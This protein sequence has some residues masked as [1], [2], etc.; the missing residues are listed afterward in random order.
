MN[1]KKII[2][3][4]CLM[5]LTTS[6][7]MFTSCKKNK[8]TDAEISAVQDGTAADGTSQETQNLA[9]QA[10]MLGTGSNGMRM[11]SNFSMLSGCATITD[12]TINNGG[13][14]DTLTVDF[15]ASPCQCHDGRFRSGKI[16][17]TY[18]GHYHDPGAVIDLHFVNYQVGPSSSDMFAINNSSTK[19]IVNNG[20]Y[21]STTFCSWTITSNMS[22]VKPNG[23]GT[24]TF[25]ES[26]Q[27]VQFAGDPNHHNVG[28][29]FYVSGTAN[30]TAAN[31]TS[32]TAAT[33]SGKDLVRDMS[34]KK[35]F[36]QG[37]LD[38][39]PSGKSMIAIDFGSGT[40]DNTA[41]ITRNG[42]TRTITLR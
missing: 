21:N 39:T 8:L 11:T 28:N 3:A 32:Y 18:T 26:K 36:T 12:D 2:V 41:T 27:R 38:I 40:C 30:G 29:K 6:T 7:L 35:H 42:V 20:L 24:I 15:G 13:N 10:K 34:C 23:G 4:A 25:S 31:G 16:I 19:H 1:Y 5:A 14:P 37:E 9:E 33:A 22:I 17:I